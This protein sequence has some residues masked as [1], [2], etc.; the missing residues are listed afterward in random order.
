MIFSV[1]AGNAATFQ[2]ITDKE[3]VYSTSSSKRSA[4]I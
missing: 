2:E 1:A 4:G 3:E